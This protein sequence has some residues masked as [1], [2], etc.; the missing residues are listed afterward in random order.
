M[1]LSIS[2]RHGHLSEPTQGKLKAKAD[3]LS[4]F[5]ERL[6][7]IELIID[8]GDQQLPKIDVKVSAE[9]KHDFLAHGEA[10]NLLGA[11]DDAMHKIEQQLRK[12]KKR[13]QQRHR[14]R[15]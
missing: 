4:H 15:S 2:T 8:L 3:K 11:M 1:Q 13:V 10:E 6:S 12:Y 9:H 7:S 5:F 14:N